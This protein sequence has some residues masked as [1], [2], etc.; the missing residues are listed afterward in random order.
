MSP[1]D[2][3]GFVEKRKELLDRS[4]A[5]P[6]FRKRGG[7]SLTREGDVV[8]DRRLT[9]LEERRLDVLDQITTVG[10]LDSL[11]ISLT[12]GGRGE[13]RRATNERR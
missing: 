4:V 5:L 13:G 9:G 1:V 3:R 10:R 7:R 6:C 12:L 8:E 2:A 11:P